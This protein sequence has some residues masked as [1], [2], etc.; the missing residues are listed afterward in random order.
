MIAYDIIVVKSAESAPD[1]RTNNN[2]RRARAGS[3]AT[4]T[5]QQQQ[6]SSV[7][8]QQAKLRAASKFCR[9]PSASDMVH[10][11]GGATK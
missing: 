1:A 9:C 10:R 8:S 11:A 6:L 4:S 5:T 7:V 2:D 3:P